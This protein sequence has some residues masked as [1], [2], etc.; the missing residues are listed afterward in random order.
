MLAVQPAH[1]IFLSLPQ[2]ARVPEQL[3][4]WVLGFQTEVFMLA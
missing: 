1:I 4:M 2:N 3:F